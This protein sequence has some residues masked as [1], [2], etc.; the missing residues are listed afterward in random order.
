[1]DNTNNTVGI[2]DT[3]SP[4]ILRIVHDK[5]DIWISIDTWNGKGQAR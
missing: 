5:K 2:K 1:M 3:V 4:L